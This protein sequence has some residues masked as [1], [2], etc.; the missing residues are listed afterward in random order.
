MAMATVRFHRLAAAEY[1]AALAWYHVRSE[2]AAWDFRDE[3]RRAIQLLETDPDQGTVFKG[4]YLWMRLRRFPF[5]L[6]YKV[7][8][9]DVVTVYAVAHARRRLGYWLRRK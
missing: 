1:R 9:P 2:K 3:I 7:I 6:Y 8:S 4:P 5:L